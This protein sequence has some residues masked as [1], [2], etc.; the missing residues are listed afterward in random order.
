MQAYCK[1]VVPVVNG[2][3][4]VPDRPGI[5]NELSDQAVAEAVARLEIC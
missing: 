1:Y 2:Y 5:G 4:T 3:I